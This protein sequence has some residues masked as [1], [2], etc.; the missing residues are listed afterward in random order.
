[1]S[2]GGVAVDG[3]GAY[4][5]TD[6]GAA[7]R[8]LDPCADDSCE[9]LQGTQSTDRKDTGTNIGGYLQM[10]SNRWYPTVEGLEDGSLIVIGGDNN[11]GELPG[12]IPISTVSLTLS[13]PFYRLRQ[14]RPSGQ[15]DLRVLPSQG[16]RQGR[17]L[18]MVGRQP[19]SQLVP[20]DLDVALR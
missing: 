13:C 9:Y 18:A 20:L 11:G 14:H 19:A 16:R 5:D 7:I 17:P 2:I 1:M 3:D 8:M 12:H 10:T 15:P 4:T 6:G